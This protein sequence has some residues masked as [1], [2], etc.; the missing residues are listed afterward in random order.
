MKKKK[1]IIMTI[2]RTHSG[3]TTLGE[4]F[5]KKKRGLVMIQTD[6]IAEFLTKN[7]PKKM[8]SEDEASGRIPDKK[9][10]KL[11]IYET[12]IEHALRINQR[13]IF[14]AN[15]NLYKEFRKKNIELFHSEN[16]KV[17]GIFLNYPASFLKKRIKESERDNSLLKT[18]DFGALVDLQRKILQKPKEEEFDYFFEIKTKEELEQA[19]KNILEIISFKKK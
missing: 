1:F 6:P 4:Y 19:K 16:Y 7:F 18:K 17:I 5:K 2:G 14:F 15:S 10:L 8:R 3:K 12:I 11:S 9:P 13:V